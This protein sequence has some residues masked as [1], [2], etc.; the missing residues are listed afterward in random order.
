[1]NRRRSHFDSHDRVA[2]RNTRTD[3]ARSRKVGKCSQNFVKVSINE[4][5]Y[6]TTFR[7][8]WRTKKKWFDSKLRR[9]HMTTISSH[10]RFCMWTVVFSCEYKRVQQ[11]RFLI[12]ADLLKANIRPL[13]F[14]LTSIGVVSWVG[15]RKCFHRVSS[16]GRKNQSILCRQ[17]LSQKWQLARARTMADGS[18]SKKKKVKQHLWSNARMRAF[19]TWRTN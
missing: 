11:G 8:A 10:Y 12:F 17:T 9:D 3:D 6:P 15:W 13:V 5:K 19:Q 4:K 18:S 16:A 14:S 1:M 2:W 7:H